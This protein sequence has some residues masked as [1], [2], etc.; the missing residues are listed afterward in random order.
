MN[1]NFSRQLKKNVKDNGISSK[2]TATFKTITFCYEKHNTNIY[3]N[4]NPI[5]Y[6][7]EFI[8][9][10]FCKVNYFHKISQVLPSELG[11][12]KGDNLTAKDMVELTNSN[13]SQRI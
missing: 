10:Q 1:G 3:T 13:N 5:A 12:L 2:V 7:V 8:W 4:A 11:Y 6:P 9:R